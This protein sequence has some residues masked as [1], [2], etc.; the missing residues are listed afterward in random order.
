MLQR[1]RT[2]PS[3]RLLQPSLPEASS[4]ISA[5]GFGFLC[6]VSLLSKERESLGNYSLADPLFPPPPTQRAQQEK[7]LRVLLPKK[8]NSAIISTSD[9]RHLE[10][11]EKPICTFD[12]VTEA[13]NTPKKF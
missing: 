6:T 11:G 1:D 10:F 3:A 7:H 13:L 9:F 8:N 4:I 5:L 12:S 2:A